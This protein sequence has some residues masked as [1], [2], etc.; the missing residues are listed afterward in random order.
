MT[1][2][3]WSG[4]L[5]RDA[6]DAL[7]LLE[8]GQRVVVGGSNAEPQELLDG[9]VAEADRLAGTVAVQWPGG[10][11]S[12]LADPRLDGKIELHVSVPNRHLRGAVRAGQAIYAPGNLHRGLRRLAAGEPPIDAALVMVSPPD[13]D[14]FC[15]L[16]VSVLA[17][18]VACRAARL[19]I[20]EVNDRM[21]RTLGEGRVH[22]DRIDA[23]LEVS[24]EVPV[25]ERRSPGPVERAI[26]EHVASIVPDG[27]TIQTGI[28][29][30]PDAVLR[31]LRGHRG[32]SVLSGIVGDGLLELIAAGA[33]AAPHGDGAPIETG[34]VL[35]GEDLY[36]FCAENE[37]VQMRSGLHTH[38]VAVLGRRRGF[39][40]INSSIEVDLSGQ[41]N[42]EAVRGE[43]VAGTGG[44][45]DFV[46][47]AQ[48]ADG[49]QSILVLPATAAGGTV[50]RIVSEFPPGTPV[51]VPRADA[52]WVVTE[53]GAVN[54]EGL[55]LAAR[56]EAM[57]SIAAPEHRDRLSKEASSNLERSGV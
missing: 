36:D 57:M 16:G 47:G 21:P 34:S 53:H 28:G 24:Y 18:S 8:A 44:L 50:S 4:R 29:S 11:P 1:T 2:A 49:G 33:L 30:M 54:L 19:V 3:R 5:R 38:D 14:G 41:V 56:A 37:D 40:A 23:A 35:G 46:R 20:A 42:A 25:M 48:L 15:S 52:G 55:S 45:G 13:A 7:S 39:C 10:F 9:L 12:R 6:A 17:L 26:G 43:I 31:A 22:L 51:T 27:A 32:I